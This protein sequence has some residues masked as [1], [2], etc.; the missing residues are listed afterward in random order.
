MKT[1][2]EIRHLMG[3]GDC[4]AFGGSGIISETIKAVTGC[5]VSHVGA[6]YDPKMYLL[7][8]QRVVQVIESTSLG[9]GFAGVKFNRLSD[10]VKYYD[11]EMWWLQMS[12]H[13]RKKLDV[14]VY[15]T[16]MLQ[17]IDKPYDTPQAIGSALDFIPDN[18]EDLD[19]IFCS[20]LLAGAYEKAGILGEINAS[21]QTPADVC[22]FWFW[23]KPVQF[24]GEEKSIER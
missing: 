21:E 17:Q 11:G 20:E 3:V 1:Y 4:I 13:A 14:A 18:R 5:N 7:D 9:E 24:K 8:G 2:E 15:M 6:I 12:D 22:K 10:H 16:F 19:K 23:N